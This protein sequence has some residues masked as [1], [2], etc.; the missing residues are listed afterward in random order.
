MSPTTSTT[1]GQEDNSK[2]SKG[3]RWQRLTAPYG[4]KQ[5]YAAFAETHA[6]A[7]GEEGIWA[8]NWT[9]RLAEYK[10]SCA[11]KEGRN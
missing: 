6:M 9:Q 5:P 4:T 10:T 3:G 7:R 1:P 11:A 8:G 2:A